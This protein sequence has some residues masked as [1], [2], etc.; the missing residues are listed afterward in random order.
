MLDD[1]DAQLNLGLLDELAVG[2][3]ADLGVGAGEAVAGEGRGVQARQGDE[4][5]AVA[6]GG[7]A[8]DVRLLL[9]AGHGRLPVEGRGEVVGESIVGE[10]RRFTG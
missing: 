4:L 6:Q 9:V 5:P 7:E 1:V 2:A 3:H 10:E 8:A